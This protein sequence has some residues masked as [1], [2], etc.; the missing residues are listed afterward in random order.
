M[1]VDS[2]IQYDKF[3][4]SIVVADNFEKKGNEDVYELF[5]ARENFED[6]ARNFGALWN[7]IVTRRDSF[8]TS[9]L[10]NQAMTI[11]DELHNIQKSDLLDQGI[12]L[13]NST[14]LILSELIIK[15]LEKYGLLPNRVSASAEGGFCLIFK[16]QDSALY[17]EVYNDGEIG[18]IVENFIQKRILDNREIEIAEVTSIINAFVKKNEFPLYSSDQQ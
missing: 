12:D 8:V 18:F 11:I 1:T 14:S 4:A 2:N 3:P 16:K 13:P 15:D 17:L 5:Q 10:N 9:A 7:E 6:Q